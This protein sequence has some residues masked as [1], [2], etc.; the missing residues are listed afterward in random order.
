MSNIEKQAEVYALV[1]EMHAII[2]ETESMKVLNTER[3]KRGFPV[4]YDQRCF[5]EMANRIRS[6][7]EEL[8]K[9][10]ECEGGSNEDE[11]VLHL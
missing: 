10:R 6:V 2:F 1:A 8:R 9:I 11:K 7:A 5:L 3:E 4:C